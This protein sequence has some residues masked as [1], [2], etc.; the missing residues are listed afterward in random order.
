MLDVVSLGSVNVDLVARL[1]GTERTELSARH[2]WFPSP[3]E[4]VAVAD[5]PGAIERFVDRHREAILGTDCLLLQNEIPVGPVEG[6]FEAIERRSRVGGRIDGVTLGLDPA[7]VVPLDSHLTVSTFLFK[8]A[9]HVLSRH[10][11]LELPVGQPLR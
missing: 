8:P 11:V 2:D 7:L 4:T 5:V 9:L 1:A 10:Q 3:D 6:L